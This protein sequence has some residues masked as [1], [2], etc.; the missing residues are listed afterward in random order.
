MTEDDKVALKKEFKQ[1][2]SDVVFAIGL[3]CGVIFGISLLYPE[4]AD[5]TPTQPSTEVVDTYK[6]CDIV[7]W[8]P[9]Q[10]AGY[11]YFLY[12]EKNQ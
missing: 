11:K 8:N 7:R 1:Y 4:W 5:N 6:E 9:H 3:A 12:C 10:F 2:M